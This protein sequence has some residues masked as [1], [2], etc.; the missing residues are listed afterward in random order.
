[1]LGVGTALAGVDG[2]IDSGFCVL[3]LAV[4]LQVFVHVYVSGEAFATVVDRTQEGFQIG[5][6]TQVA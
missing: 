5:V 1:M 3:V 6:A 2:R 4:A